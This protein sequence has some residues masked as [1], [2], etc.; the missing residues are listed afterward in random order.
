MQ[1]AL[2]GHLY[3]VQEQ[4]L[5]IF[6]HFN[7]SKIPHQSTIR[8]HMLS[9]AHTT[10]VAGPFYIIAEMRK[11][12]TGPGADIWHSISAPTIEHLYT[13]L[14]PNAQ[15]VARCISC[16][17]ST[18]K[19]Q[20][21]YDWLLRYISNL[22]QMELLLFLRFVTGV[23]VLLGLEKLMVSFESPPGL[24]KTARSP[25]ARTCFSTLVLHTFYDRYEELKSDFDNLLRN[26]KMWLLDD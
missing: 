25:R 22:E 1:E 13:Q 20:L 7:F 21:V 18:D 4:V 19:E 5:L 12:L 16:E 24:S 8:Q 17:P 11:G 26:H 15:K 6:A 3:K 10:L 14:Q 2:E 23:E 9:I